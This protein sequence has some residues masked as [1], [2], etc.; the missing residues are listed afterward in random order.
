MSTLE[1]RV[2]ALEARRQRETCS[3]RG[4]PT[5][6]IL[7]EALSCYLNGRYPGGRQAL[8]FPLG[9]SPRQLHT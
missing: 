3:L 8:G 1:A 2:A 6:S 7:V 9:W 5:F 4:T